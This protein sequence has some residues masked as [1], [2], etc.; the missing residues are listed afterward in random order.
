MNVLVYLE[1]KGRK[2]AELENWSHN[3]QLSKL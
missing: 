1:K 2:N 3:L